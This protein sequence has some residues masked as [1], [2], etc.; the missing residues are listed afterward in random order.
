MAV[1]ETI[2]ERAINLTNNGKLSLFEALENIDLALNAAS[3]IRI[4]HTLYKISSLIFNQKLLVM[5]ACQVCQ[6]EEEIK[7]LLY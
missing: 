3:V 2:D 4:Y 6:T 1:R 7:T 5:I